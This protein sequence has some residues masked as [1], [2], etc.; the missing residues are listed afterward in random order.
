MILY[1]GPGIGIA[2]FIIVGIVLLI[3]AAS[4][5]ILILRPVRKLLSKIKK[6]FKGT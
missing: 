4:I 3:V 5:V 2:T 1:I 6:I